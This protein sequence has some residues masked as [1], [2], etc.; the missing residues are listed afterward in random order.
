[1][2]QILMCI[3]CFNIFQ[4]AQNQLYRVS[5]LYEVCTHY[6]E[7]W[8]SDFN[9]HEKYYRVLMFNSNFR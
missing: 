1:M 5:A 7:R 9:A 6:N 8:K 2:F 4:K 3:S